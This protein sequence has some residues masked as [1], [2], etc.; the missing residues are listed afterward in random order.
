MVT[1]VDLAAP[2]REARELRLG[3]CGGSEQKPSAIAMHVQDEP[4]EGV[5]AE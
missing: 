4:R 3:Q 1:G 5:T 2:A